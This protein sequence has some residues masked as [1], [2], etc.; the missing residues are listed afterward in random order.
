MD[1]YQ[2][3][4]VTVIYGHELIKCALKVDPSKLPHDCIEDWAESDNRR[5]L[6]RELPLHVQSCGEIVEVEEIF[7]IH[8]ATEGEK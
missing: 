7:A 5:A 4:L 3:L 1:K 6:W 2:Y 8:D